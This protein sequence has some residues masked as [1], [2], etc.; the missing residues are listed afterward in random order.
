MVTA[1]DAAKER[2]DT[3]YTDAQGRYTLKVDFKGPATLRARAPYYKDDTRDVELPAGS[4]AQRLDFAL[5][6]HTVAAELSASLSASAQLSKL[7]FPNHD[8]R[9]AFISQ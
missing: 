9:S 7:S 5:Q 1:I 6:R 2:R 4:A 3:V 8:S